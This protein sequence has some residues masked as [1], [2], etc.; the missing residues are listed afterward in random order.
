MMKVTDYAR[1]GVVPVDLTGG[2]DAA[3]SASAF[4]K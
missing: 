4:A 3:A 1:V 2:D